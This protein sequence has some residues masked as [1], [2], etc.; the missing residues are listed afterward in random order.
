MTF[1]HREYPRIPLRADTSGAGS[2]WIATEKIHGASF[3]IATDGHTVRCGKRRAWLDP[4][5]TFFGWQ[6]LRTR[7]E[8][9]ARQ[10]H[11]ELGDG[12]LV[13]VYGELFGGGY[14]HASVEPIPGLVPVQT[15]VY[16]LPELDFAVFDILHEHP[17]PCFVSYADL[18]GLCSSSGL[19]HAPLVRRGTRSEVFAVSPDRPT[20]VPT[21][22]GLP[23]L[24]DN[25]A[26]G[27]V[28]KPAAALPPS[29]R[30]VVKH[31]TERFSE[32]RFGEALPFDSNAH[33]SLDELTVLAAAMINPPRIASARSKLGGV[34]EQ[35]LQD[36]VV[37]DVLTDLEALLPACFAQL[38]P[39][40]A[41]AL[42]REVRVRVS[43][44]RTP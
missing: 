33:L 5:D 15:G 27:V 40:D 9:A 21:E 37:L 19:Y 39:E 3:V 35:A 20:A 8:H 24:P 42:E 1:I 11:R 30:P 44:A 22:R 23:P 16:Y 4:Q 26:E 18:V 25:I 41:D 2:Q 7:L 17:E 10:I 32:T 14:P 12:G 29:R 6:L 31:K 13:R 38:G 43:S 36:E 28:L 34:D